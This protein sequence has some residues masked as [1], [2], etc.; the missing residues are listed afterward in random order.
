[1]TPGMI[2]R[3]QI[4]V[5]GPIQ[6]ARLASVAAGTGFT[7]A[8]QLDSDAPFILRSRALRMTYTAG[9]QQIDNAL[10]PGLNH[11]LMRWS[12]PER[13]YRSQSLIRQSLVGPYFGQ[14]G[15]PIPVYPEVYYPKQGEITVDLFNDGAQTITGLTFY[16]LGVKLFAEG[17]VKSYRYPAKFGLLPY[18]YSLTPSL[19]VQTAGLRQTLNVKSDA[20]FVWRAGQAGDTF[21]ANPAFEVY[22]R[23]RDEDEKPYMN[24][25]VHADVLFGNSNFGAVYVDVPVGAGPAC[26]GLIYPEIYIPK[27]HVFYIDV[28]RNDL[29]VLNAATVNYPISLIG[30]KVFTK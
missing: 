14:I 15:N 5:L 21:D 1:M 13:D 22:I 27:N 29:T 24:S 18:T 28:S 7:T 30:Q 6:D 26:P 11:V 2:E 19:P 20:D 16:F 3:F 23:L 4:Y 12:G 25:G 9:R 17:A 10:D 8:L